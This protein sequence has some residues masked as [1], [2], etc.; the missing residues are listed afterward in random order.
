M[1]YFKWA[2]VLFSL[3]IAFIIFCGWLITQ[4]LW[5]FSTS[6]IVALTIALISVLYLLNKRAKSVHGFKKFLAWLISFVSF[7]M[8][9]LLLCVLILQLIVLLLGGVSHLTTSISPDQRYKIHFY[10]FDAGAMGTF[11]VRGEL[12]GPLG[13]KKQIYYERH[14]TEVHVEWLNHHIISIN[15]NEL[16][17]KN[18]DYFGYTLKP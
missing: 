4:T 10:Y 1:H 6:S 15:G 14:A 16:N 9:V 12:N 2:C 3:C 18:G 5:T 7:L 11:G 13:F 8:T 17:L